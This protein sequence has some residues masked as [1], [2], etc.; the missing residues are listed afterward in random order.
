MAALQPTEIWC[1]MPDESVTSLAQ[2]FRNVALVWLASKI[3][4]M[5]LDAETGW[6][7]KQVCCHRRG[8]VTVSNHLSKANFF[9]SVATE[10]NDVKYFLLLQSKS[11]TCPVGRGLAEPAQV[12]GTGPHGVALCW[13]EWQRSGYSHH[14]KIEPQI[15]R[16]SFPVAACTYCSVVWRLPGIPRG[17]RLL[18]PNLHC[19]QRSLPGD[20]ECQWIQ[21]A[22]P[23]QKSK[24][25]SKYI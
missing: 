12:L 16:C 2:A 20:C 25:Y 8:L 18:W 11:S 13:L 3:L 1:H 10:F 14:Q 9:F 4:S 23:T 24:Y 21:M 7:T 19:Q 5:G 17:P 15:R 22:K 6:S